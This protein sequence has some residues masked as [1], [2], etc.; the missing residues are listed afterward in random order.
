MNSKRESHIQNQHFK[1]QNAEFT[2][3][4]SEE[5]GTRKSTSSHFIKIKW[6]SCL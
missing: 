4:A 6:R 1:P 5:L 2:M 3:L